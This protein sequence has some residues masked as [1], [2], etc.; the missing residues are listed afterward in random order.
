[1]KRSSRFVSWLLW[2]LKSERRKLQSSLRIGDLKP[3]AHPRHIAKP[4]VDYGTRAFLEL[5]RHFTVDGYLPG[6]SKNHHKLVQSALNGLIT[7]EVY[8]ASFPMEYLHGFTASKSSMSNNRTRGSQP[9]MAALGKL[10]DDLRDLEGKTGDSI[11]DACKSWPEL[12]LKQG[13]RLSTDSWHKRYYWSNSGGSHH[14]A[15]LCHELLRQNKSWTPTLE[16]REHKLNLS[17]LKSLVGKVTIFVVMRGENFEGIDQVFLPLPRDLRCEEVRQ[18]L[19]VSVPLS[20]YLQ[21]P[22]SDYQFVIIDHSRQYADLALT[23]LQEAITKGLAL[24][25]EDFLKG[26]ISAPLID[27][28]VPRRVSN[29]DSRKGL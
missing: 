5:F 16:I 4:T 24:T 3:V 23:V 20:P 2:T 13:I 28:A 27:L 1:M 9:S 8:T 11:I 22:F 26:W 21:M 29:G 15:V 14:M 19:G 6:L 12:R 18:A 10:V 17:S 7:T 25:F